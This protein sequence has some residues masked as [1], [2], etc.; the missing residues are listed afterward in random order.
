[1]E[2]VY[3]IFLG[4]AYFAAVGFLV[5]GLDDLFLDW[6]FLRYLRKRDGRETVSLERL[7]NEPEQLI[8]V[9]IPAW[10]ESGVIDRMVEFAAKV[11]SYDRYDIFVGVY[12]NDTE[13][14]RCVEALARKF[15]RVHLAMTR[16][17]GPTSKADCLNAIYRAM[18]AREIPGQREYQ[19]IA[20]HD[21]EDVLHPLTLKVYNYHVPRRFDMGQI[22]VFPLELT[23]WK[24]WVGNTYVDEFTE[25]H[26]KD[27]YARE[28]MGGVVPS[29]GVGT[30]FS[31]AAIEYLAAKN[32]GS[33]FK[34]GQ[35]A[36]D[37]MVGLELCRSGYRAGFIDYPVER[38]VTR[39]R[40]DGRESKKKVT[41]LV[42]VRE[43]FPHKFFQSVKQ[44][45]R[46]IIGTAFQGW[47]QGG[48]WG[49]PA[50]R[51][52]L[53]RDRKAPLVHGINLA[54]Y[55][56]VGYVVFGWGLSATPWHQ[57]LFVRP[58]FEPD[59]LLWRIVLLDLGL[60]TYRVAQKVSFVSRIYGWR[61]ALYAIPRYPVGNFV[62]MVATVRAARLYLGHRLL[63]RELAWT[64]TRH[65]F[66]GAEALS[67]FERSIEDLVVEEGYATREQLEDAVRRN[68]NL[69][70]PEALLRLNLI[71]EEQYT[72]LWKKFTGLDE[73]AVTIEDVSGVLFPAWTEDRA[74]RYRAMPCT[75]GGEE[76]V[77]FVFQE[78]P[79][80]AA[81]AE[82]EALAGGRVSPH[83]ARP[84]NL[85]YLRNRV[86]PDRAPLVRRT[87]PLRPVL[88]DL[89]P[90]EARRVREFQALQNRSLADAM[91]AL[92]FVEAGEARA[93]VASA[94]GAAAADLS[95]A[96][97]DEAM[98]ARIGALFCDVHGI[99][100]LRQGGLAIGAMPHPETAA[101]LRD[102][103]GATPQFVSDLPQA[104]LD[105]W[106]RMRSRR[107]AEAALTDNLAGR[108][109]L[110]AGTLARIK[111]MQRLVSDPAD[112]LLQQLGM[113]TPESVHAALV[114]TS[115]LRVWAESNH[116][117]APPNGLE[118][119]LAPGF[120]AKSG[121][122]IVE[123]ADGRV[124]FG[125][126]GLPSDDELLEIFQRCAGAMV[127]FR[128]EG[129]P[130]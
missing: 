25:L 21:A 67:E 26:L 86:Y 78:P 77:G 100:P 45:A 14:V 9:F 110:P 59:S 95:A 72:G 107:L 79:S 28:E 98:V 24:H 18:R 76:G 126:R 92:G 55:A 39:R 41:E 114:A 118:A 81:T 46:W 75:A 5:F 85:R 50:V 82:I 27:M 119:L 57:S 54:G 122:R 104:F 40:G 115:G 1:M 52:T 87:D 2:T 32:G 42:A 103:L 113:A 121:L 130:S 116:I 53:A 108:G 17:P 94:A 63:G 23:P 83:L 33:P 70:A 65:D 16:S 11:L 36:E 80:A 102:Q 49:T 37:Y 62:N 51:Y 93:L 69:S 109:Q 111:E 43:H 88:Q 7:K 44:K 123:A 105:L 91:V 84:G 15:P 101:V 96:E 4:L 6:Q 19:L 8:A 125:L 106:R 120:A 35:L 64:K 97:I 99:V 12:P 29:A 48:W 73:R 34:V 117:A 128:L 66:P 58:L 56:V 10:Q 112:R 60:L 68:D 124:G 38:E 20:L 127:R 61:H 71:D 129:T 31:R 13:T 30:A 3:Y 22:P 90:D 47:E 89:K 74:C